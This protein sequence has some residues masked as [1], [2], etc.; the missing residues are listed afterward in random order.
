[1][2]NYQQVLFSG[3][4]NNGVIKRLSDGRYIPFDS[5]NTDY[6][7]YL[8]WLAEGNTPEPAEVTNG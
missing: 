4:V 7:A 1:M 6:Q 5:D 8:A 3:E 2:E